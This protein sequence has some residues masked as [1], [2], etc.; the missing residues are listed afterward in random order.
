MTLHEFLLRVLVVLQPVIPA[1]IAAAA[2][3]LLAVVITAIGVHGLWIDQRKFRWL[4]IFY[5][6]STSDCLHLACAWIELVLLAVF[7]ISFRKLTAADYLLFLIP[8]GLYALQFKSLKKIP[9]RLLWL[10]LEFVGLLSA[11]LV[12]GYYHDM[13]GGLGF[14]LVY[15]IM[16]V[17]MMLFGCYL[18]LTE[19]SDISEGRSPVIEDEQN[20]EKE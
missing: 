11:N 6:L 17:F 8:G 5:G 7:L 12:C 3:T 4:G 20:K 13:H 9:V 19:L 2:V 10:A 1:V 16:A 14:A 18:F 15:V